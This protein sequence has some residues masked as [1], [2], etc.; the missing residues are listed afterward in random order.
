MYSILAQVA[1]SRHQLI[2]YLIWKDG[3]NRRSF[4]VFRKLRS[5]REKGTFK[6]NCRIIGS[7]ICWREAIQCRYIGSDIWVFCSVTMIIYSLDFQLPSISTITNKNKSKQLYSISLFSSLAM[8]ISD[9][10]LGVRRYHDAN[11]FFIN[12]C[13]LYFLC[14]CCSRSASAECVYSNLAWNDCHKIL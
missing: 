14:L 2:E 4:T 12:F 11:I 1:R 7:H 8:I 5:W 9:A 3:H 10:N 6:W 13:K